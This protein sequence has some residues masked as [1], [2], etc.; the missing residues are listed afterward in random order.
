[1]TATAT[2]KPDPYS[3]APWTEAEE[4]VALQD[5]EILRKRLAFLS[6]PTS[7]QRKLIDSVPYAS[8]LP[9]YKARQF[10]IEF[11]RGRRDRFI[12]AAGNAFSKS[13]LL[14]NILAN[15]CF[16][17]MAA[18]LQNLPWYKEWPFFTKKI[19][20]ASEPSTLEEKTASELMKW[21]PQGRYKAT[22]GNF[23]F[24]SRFETDTGF[25]IILRSYEQNPTKFESADISLVVLDEPPPEWLWKAIPARQRDGGAVIMGLTPMHGATWMVEGDSAFLDMDEKGVRAKPDKAKRYFVMTGSTW[26]NLADGEDDETH[27]ERY[28][29]GYV[30]AIAPSPRDGFLTR[31]AIDQMISE[32]NEDEIRARIEGHFMRLGRR[33][34]PGFS[35]ERQVATEDMLVDEPFNWSRNEYGELAPPP[36]WTRY[37][38]LDPHDGKSWA[39]G[40]FAVSPPF[41]GRPYFKTH[42]RRAKPHES[43]HILY[44]EWPQTLVSKSDDPGWGIDQY[45]AKINEL[46]RDEYVEGRVI[47]PNYGNQKRRVANGQITIKAMLQEVGLF[48]IDGYDAQ[49]EGH[50][51]VRTAFSMS[52][53]FEHVYPLSLLMIAETCPQAIISHM[54]Y[55]RRKR[56]GT[57]DEYLDL[58]EERFKDM[59]DVIRYYWTAAFGWVPESQRREIRTKEKSALD[60]WYD[61]DDEAEEERRRARRR[62]RTLDMPSRIDPVTGVHEADRLSG[63]GDSRPIGGGVRSGLVRY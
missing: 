37:M 54:N 30:P 29:G 16:E 46:E 53:S 9:N 61:G 2:I 3:E 27:P 13:A 59:C 47:D 41:T 14:S 56:H 44:R 48:F 5:P 6:G 12:V 1:V 52:P 31:P 40:W 22:K 15:I 63:H 55:Q 45:V 25:E 4:A 39:M 57:V 19:W 28:S 32:Y 21:F 17:P 24:Y 18:W 62:R 42:E 20:M 58:P 60:R 11:G 26:D 38:A 34:Y 10:M 36:D 7:P 50:Q 49:E 35:R 51:S 8:F 43:I 33:I 23:N